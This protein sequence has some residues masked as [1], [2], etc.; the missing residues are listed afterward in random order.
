[1]APRQPH[2]RRSV[3]ATTASLGR[4]R[5][6]ASTWLAIMLCCWAGSARAATRDLVV[7]LDRA[8]VE[9]SG[10]RLIEVALLD[11]ERIVGVES[12][13]ESVKIE[14]MGHGFVRGHSLAALRIEA[15]R[16]SVRLRIHTQDGLATALRQLRPRAVIL[17]TSGQAARTADAGIWKTS[18]RVAIATSS[19]KGFRP[20]SYPDLEGS[21]VRYLVISS[22]ALAADFQVLADW[23]T[24][25]GTP[26]VVRTLDWIEAH[27]RRGSDRA[28]T[29][30]N[31][32]QDAYAL[33][34][35]DWVLLGGDTD[36]V[37]TR[38][39]SSNVSSSTSLVPTDL[40]FAC[41][42]GTWNANRNAL[43]GEPA[44]SAMNLGDQADL[45]PEVWVSRAPVRTSI[46][47]QRFV[48]KSIRYETPFVNTYQ[49][50]ALFLAEVLSPADYDSGQAINL[51]G[52]ALTE[53][54]RA[55]T[56]PMTVSQTRQYET[57]FLYPGSTPI[58]KAAAL[59]ALGAG[60]NL[61][62][63]MGHGY[64]YNMSVGDGSIV[65]AEA[66]AL[67][68][69]DRTYVM[70]LLNCTALAFD[71]NS[72]GERF[73]LA[74][75]GGA[76]GVI[77]SSREAY[78]N[79]AIEYN[80]N[81]FEELFANGNP[82]LGSA[83]G[84]ARQARTAFTFF[85]TQ[86]RWTHFILNALGD[87]NLAIWTGPALA[88]VVTHPASVA[89]D[90]ASVLVHVEAAATP[91][92]NAT[93]CLW[94]GDEYYET[95]TTNAMGDATVPL[96]L[97]TTGSMQCTVVGTNLQTYLGSISVSGTAPAH[98]HVSA[99]TV[100]D[101]AVAPSAGNGDGKLDA[102]EIVELQVQVTNAGGVVLPGARA[103]LSLASPLVTIPTDS[104]ALGA[105]VPAGNASGTFVVQLDAGLADGTTLPFLVSFVDGALMKQGSDRIPLVVH[106]PKLELVEVTG[107][108]ASG[109]TAFDLWVRNYGSGAAPALTAVVTSTDPDVTV[110]VGAS[111]LATIASFATGTT[112][113]PL[114]TTETTTAQRN[115]MH[116]AF[117]DAYG[118]VGGFDFDLRAPA[119]ASRPVLD[120]R[121]G[122]TV[123]RLTWT[124]S[125]DADLLGYHVYRRPAGVGSLTRVT[126]DVIRAAYA[127]DT[128]L[129]ASTRYDWAVA[130]VDSGGRVG[131]LSPSA[132]ASTNPP[133]LAGWP[134]ALPAS[135]ASSVAIGDVDGDGD[136]DVLVGDAGIYAWD[137]N[138]VELRD[139]DSDAITW[140]AF[141]SIANTVTGAIALAQLDPVSAGLEIVAAHWA[142][143]QVYAYDGQ[144]NVLPGWPREPMLGGTA[145]Y[146]GT[147]TAADLD[148]DG[149]AEV[150]VI[151]KNGHLYGWDFDGT[152][153]DGGDGSFA[154]V[155]AFTRTSPTVVNLDGDPALEIV[156]ASSTGF[157]YAYEP[158]GTSI[159]RDGWPVAL[160]AASLSS[161]AVGEI[162]GNAS[163]A[164]IVV[165]SEN[166]LVHVLNVLGY[167]L[168]GWPK[169]AAMDSPSF[170]PSPALGDMNGDGRSEIAVVAN[171]SPATLSTLIVYDGATGA[172]LLTKLLGNSSEASPILADVDGDGNVDVVVGGESGVVNAWNL[173]GVQLDGFPLTT[174]DYVRSTPAFADVD[175]DGGAELVLAGWNRNLYVWDLTA[176]YD[177]ARA[178]WPTY[179]H[180]AA[181]TGN[182]SHVAVSDGEVPDVRAHFWLSQSQPNPFNP[183][184]RVS[185]EIG[186]SGPVVVDV[187][188]ARG[189]HVRTLFEGT[190]AAGRHTFTWDGRDAA[191]IARPSGVYWL[192]A[193][194]ASHRATRKLTLVR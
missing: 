155:G 77:G 63:H 58:S 116:V 133:Q 128:G 25:R 53:Q 152:P 189:R 13:G 124:P 156:V 162:D 20:S 175:G 161:P 110:D 23:K 107:T 8:A 98:L 163:T 149:R 169:S 88:P 123:M 102:G 95:A 28:E 125:N 115:L 44:V 16:G 19:P 154:N 78:P 185:L 30:R 87:P 147:P 70:F 143:N 54:L 91:V 21:P 9:A 17:D 2:R 113:V 12:L 140:G 182:A 36:V 72:L 137:A 29:M 173:A 66:E 134:L 103:T 43:W 41:L 148:G 184:T 158:D 55:A 92:A 83:L 101:D 100:D 114:Q 5:G 73:V 47:A 40:Y 31:F 65:N 93:V 136:Q 39:A 109:T 122:P 4:A 42:D 119:T 139:G 118:R 145:G 82:Y 111:S 62:N 192:R 193:D 76:V 86:D 48:Q 81:F 79:T 64:L 146:W 142:D 27:A 157:V 130:A 69:G 159:V 68:N 132:T 176:P 179:C 15:D 144:G 6:L 127:L 80:E 94:K 24:R 106:A 112:L 22:S 45:Y 171:K 177:P 60:A 129:L 168:P 67:A 57:H 121:E 51:D 85:D 135:T 151:G 37:P 34:G 160:G 11:G 10:A 164:E 138:G 3:A 49:N 104:I 191:G 167:A 180:D 194:A 188:D 75:N 50:E 131:P 170:G 120:A 46:E 89:V 153:L 52:A 186:V 38:F 59:A 97:D 178:P 105:L 7:D 74:P 174:G 1:M 33:W 108:T 141:T 187:Y 181:R 61:V 99:V 56:V 26:A 165:T 14:V 150:L 126:Q 117:T 166:D 71:S 18:E 183:T 35:V 90:A 84:A 32:L 96:D 172:V 190:L